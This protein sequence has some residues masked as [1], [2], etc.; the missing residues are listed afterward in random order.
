MQLR[1]MNPAD[2]QQLDEI[3]ATVESRDYLH[4]ARE[5]E[6]FTSIW[7]LEQRPLREKL[8]QPN[9]LSDDLRFSYRQVVQGVDE[10]TAL[11]LEVEGTPVAAAVARLR[12]EVGT[13]ELLDLR[14]DY[15]HRRQGFGMAMLY[16]LINIARAGVAGEGGEVRALYAEVPANNVPAAELLGRVGFELSGFDERRRSNHDLVKEV[17]TMLWYL[18]LEGT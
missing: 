3:D 4:L 11:A 17:A 2:L 18:P 9:R 13:L 14:V 8:I 1:R 7:R 16:E 15:D 6:G 12:P 10:G 5:G